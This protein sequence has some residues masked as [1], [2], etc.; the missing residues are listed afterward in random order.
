MRLLNFTKHQMGKLEQRKGWYRQSH[1]AF[2][3]LLDFVPNWK[4]AYGR[5]PG[6]GLI[7][8]QVFLPADSAH[9]GFKEI[10][11]RQQQRGMV[12]YLGVLKRHRPDP[13]LLT[14]GL[15][16]WSMAMDFKVSDERRHDLSSMCDELTRLVL[17]RGGRFYFAKDSVL[18]PRAVEAMYD[19][20]KLAAFRALKAELDP[21]EL[22]QTDL[23]RR[24][25][26]TAGVY[27]MSA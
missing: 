7:Q 2:N 13:F 10:L 25:F 4:F 20:D 15:D 24:A 14:H 17:E 26:G 5:R 19:R 27:T 16:G 11:R 9:D 1:A 23:W 8:Y 18:G 21:D 6:T 3:F 12:S 22:L